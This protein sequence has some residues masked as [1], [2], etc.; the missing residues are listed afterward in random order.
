[1]VVGDIQT[2]WELADGLEAVFRGY[3]DLQRCAVV[4]SMAAARASSVLPHWR[5]LRECESVA[6]AR[7]L[8]ASSATQ[9]MEHEAVVDEDGRLEGLVV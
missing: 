4:A 7:Q 6:L 8:G 9:V 2:R 3:N 1:M 5:Q